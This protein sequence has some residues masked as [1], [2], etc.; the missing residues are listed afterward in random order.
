[1][2]FK[3]TSD[4]E[5]LT[6]GTKKT[7]FK[8]GG[9]NDSFTGGSGKDIFFYAKNDKGN[10]T[11]ADFDFT[12]DKVKIASGTITNISTVSG[13]IKFDMNSGR[14]NSANVG[15]FQIGNIVEGYDNNGA[16]ATS[17]QA[18]I[19]A[20]NTYYWFADDGDKDVNGNTFA[21]GALITSDKKVSKSATDGY[22]VIDL[23]Y[24]TNLVKAGVAYKTTQTLPKKTES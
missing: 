2:T 5:T 21:S 6:G 12:N 3:G 13:G 11:I 10:T 17:K 1:M 14:K 16:K 7:T 18:V 24:S 15:S 8:G 20:N 22:A 9:G 19:K 4:A 23:G